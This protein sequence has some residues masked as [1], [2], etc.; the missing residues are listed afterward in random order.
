MKYCAKCGKE[1]MDDAVICPGC[2]CA[3][4]KETKVKQVSYDDCVKGA[5]TTNIISV[6]IL[7][8]GVL[9][10]LF[11][12]VLVGAVLCLV[13]EIL[14]LMPNSK[15]QK[16]FKSNN[17]SL[18]KKEFKEKAKQ[19]KKDMKAKYSAYKFSFVIGYLALAGVI[20]FALLL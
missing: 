8:A 1:I 11:V 14:V 19:C 9:C 2:G 4:A 16:A 3:I 10:G 17:K 15:L 5:A 7:A 20:V 12:S 13:A 18:D 6:L